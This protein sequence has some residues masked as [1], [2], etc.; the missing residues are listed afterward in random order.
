MS[1]YLL[2]Y[3]RPAFSPSRIFP[4]C[5]YFRIEMLCKMLKSGLDRPAALI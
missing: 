4:Q 2:I 3:G 5:A 1:S